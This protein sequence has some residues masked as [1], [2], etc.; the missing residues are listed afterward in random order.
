MHSRLVAKLGGEGPGSNYFRAQFKAS[1]YQLKRRDDC[2]KKNIESLIESVEKY[3]YAD[4]AK[5]ED[6]EV[7]N[8]RK[9]E[10]LMEPKMDLP[11]LHNAEQPPSLSSPQ[12]R[13]F[14]ETHSN[15]SSFLKK[16]LSVL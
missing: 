1:R 6:Q 5:K 9:A 8:Y 13:R 7:E 14:P 3:I 11:Q 16:E 2:F 12:G 4:D 10:S 15:S